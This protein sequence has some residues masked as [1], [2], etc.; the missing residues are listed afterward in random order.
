MEADS[1][2]ATAKISWRL[3]LSAIKPLIR[4]SGSEFVLL[5][6]TGDKFHGSSL[7]EQSKPLNRGS[8]ENQEVVSEGFAVFNGSTSG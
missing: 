6:S 5:Q 1:I 4:D 3:D 2:L 8:A 7:L